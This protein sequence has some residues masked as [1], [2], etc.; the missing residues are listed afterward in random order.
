MVFLGCGRGFDCRFEVLVLVLSLIPFLVSRLDVWWLVWIWNCFCSLGF[1]GI[2]FV[3][4]FFFH[5][6]LAGV[7]VIAC[8]YVNTCIT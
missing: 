7:M 2:H 3:S 6:C 5:S 4:L 1:E 8:C